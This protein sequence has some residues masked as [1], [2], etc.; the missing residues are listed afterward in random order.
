MIQ[1]IIRC[2]VNGCPFNI[3]HS[4]IKFL[5]ICPTSTLNK[6]PKNL[7]VE[8]HSPK[9]PQRHKETQRDTK[10]N[11]IFVS[12]CANFS[13]HRFSTK[14]HIFRQCAKHQGLRFRQLKSQSFFNQVFNRIYGFKFEF[15]FYIVRY[16]L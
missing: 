9:K 2:R 12:L 11:K 10:R 8:F 7:I 16:I 6:F 5:L 3:F 1:P 13:R 15:L 4:M 14:G